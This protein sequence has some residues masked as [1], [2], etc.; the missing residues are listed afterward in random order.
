M[1]QST[2]RFY[3][4]CVVWLA[5]TGTLPNAGV[6]AQAGGQD[7]IATEATREAPAQDESLKSAASKLHALELLLQEKESKREFGNPC[8]KDAAQRQTAFLMKYIR[9]HLSTQELRAVASSCKAIPSVVNDWSTFHCQLFGAIADILLSSCDR[10]TFVVLLSIRCPADVGYGNMI[11]YYVARP[12]T[13]I[14]DSDLIL[15]DAFTMSRSPEARHEIAAALRRGFAGLGVKGKDDADFVANALKWY[16]V[17]RARVKLNDR[18]LDNFGTLVG[19]PDDY[20][21]NPLY[22]V[23]AGDGQGPAR[24]KKEQAR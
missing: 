22:V 10:D 8:T 21:R 9:E 17:N 4:G 18:Y 7:G 14:K 23:K 5:N 24:Q 11:E 20:L 12:R 16:N 19:R 6:P 3:L 1:R 2:A 15:F 13:G